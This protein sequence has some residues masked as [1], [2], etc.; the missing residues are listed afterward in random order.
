MTDERLSNWKIATLAAWHA[1]AATTRADTEDVAD[2][3][4]KWA[5]SRFGWKKYPQYPDIRIVGEALRDAKKAK[6]GHLLDGDERE[7]GWLLT[8]GGID[9]ATTNRHLLADLSQELGR[10]ALP[11]ED[12]SFLKSLRSSTLY[13]RW[14]SG[15]GPPSRFQAADALGLTAD[16]PIQV[17][18]HRLDEAFNGAI[19]GQYQDLQ[20]Y[21]KW[22]RAAGKV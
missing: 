11:R 22:L 2:L 8:T 14:E 1:G 3:C 21:V 16:A 10:S 12:D 7:G 5:P 9:W 15:Q 17:F 18:R 6:N 13:A 19:V 4:W 20:E